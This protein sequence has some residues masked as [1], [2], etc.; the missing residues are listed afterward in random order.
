M[1]PLIGSALISAG[2]SLLG[3][4]FG[5]KSSSSASSKNRKFQE[6]VYKNQIQWRVEDAKKAGLHPLYALGAPSFS[7]SATQVGEDYSF[8]GDAARSIADAF[9]KKAVAEENKEILDLKKEKLRAEIR[10][11]NA[12]AESLRPKPGLLTNDDLSRLMHDEFS[13]AVLYGPAIQG[14]KSRLNGVGKP[15]L[16]GHTVAVPEETPHV[17]LVA[18]LSIRSIVLS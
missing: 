12:R 8:I 1:D 10:E 3:G 7:P 5:H 14:L 2:G 15:R 6:K 11:T 17:P 4:L 13:Q 18:P 16:P 9:G